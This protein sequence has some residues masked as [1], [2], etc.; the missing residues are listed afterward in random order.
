LPAID[1]SDKKISV[2]GNSL[3]LRGQG[4][5]A[6]FEKY[7]NDHRFEVPSVFGLMLDVE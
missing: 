5:E 4:Q 1:V 7:F 3:E 6:A 2:G